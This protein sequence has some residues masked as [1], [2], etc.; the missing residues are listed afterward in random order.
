MNTIGNQKTPEPETRN[1]RGFTLIEL[2]VVISII[3]VLAGFTIPVLMSVKRQQYIKVA[4]AELEQLQT[5]LENY[6][7][8]YGVYPPSNKSNPKINDLFYELIGTT[9]PDKGSTYQTLD[10]FSTIPV[11]DLTNTFNVSGIINCTKGSAED[12]VQAE[13]FLSGLKSNRIGLDTNTPSYPPTPVYLLVTSV[14][15]PDQTYQPLGG[16]G[17]NPFR[18]LNPGTNNPGS[19]DLWVQLVI[20]GKTNLI[21]NWSKQVLFNSPLP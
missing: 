17:I 7:A 12:S 19:Y 3:G 1:A 15:G 18:Y 13:N 21:C 16:A 20:G 9:T 14:G 2:L 8:K 5:A 11:A 10:G 4:R 6:K